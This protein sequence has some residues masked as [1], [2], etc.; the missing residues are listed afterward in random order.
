MGKSVCRAITLYSYHIPIKE[1]CLE[2]QY[3]TIGFF[4][5]MSTEALDIEYEKEDLKALWQY[6][7]KRTKE[8][9]GSY[10]FQNIFALADDEWNSNCTDE[11]FWSLPTDKQYP[12]TFVVCLQLKEYL[13]GYR[14]IRKQCEKF[15]T[16][17]ETYLE[18][19]L[20]YTYSSIDKNEFVVCLKCR[21]YHKAVQTIQKLHRE[22]A[23]CTYQKNVVVYGY[24][25][26]SVNHNV[27]DQMSQD[28]Y[29][30]LYEEKIESIC[31]KGITNSIK[32]EENGLMLDDK[33]YDFCEKLAK[34]LYFGGERREIIECDNGEFDGGNKDRTYDILGDDDFRYIAR[35]V[36]LGR[37]LY[38]YRRDGMLSYSDKGFAFYLFSSSLVL[39]TRTETDGKQNLDVNWV[40]EAGGRMAVMMVPKH[41]NEVAEILRNIYDIISSK[42]PMNDRILSIYYA[43]HQLLQSFK[44]LELSPAKRYDFFSMFP[45]FKMLVE[46]VRDKLE[47]EE[48]KKIV[49]QNEMFDFIH[50]ISMTF[51]SAQRTDIQFF[52][53]Q[54][55]NV[56]VHYAPAKLRAFY[57]AWILNLADLYKQFKGNDLKDYS[58]IFAPG[59]FGVTR[60][61]QLFFGGGETKRLMLVTL[62]DRSVYQ[63]K[64]LLIVLSHEAAHVGCERQRERRHKFAL[65]VCARVTILEMHAF[66]TWEING[67]KEH[68]NPDIFI[69]RIRND[70]QLLHEL[71]E[72]LFEEN[73]MIYQQFGAEEPGNIKR[74]DEC[75]RGRSRVH[76]SEAFTEML[77]KYGEKN[78]ADYC[79]QIKNEYIEAK[80]GSVT[81]ND[82]SACLNEIGIDVQKEM[83]EFIKGFHNVQLKKILKI[84]YNIEEEAFSDLITILTLEHSMEDYFLSF[85]ADEITEE[86]M[87]E[88]T[89]A[90]AVIVRMALVIETVSRIAD[91]SWLSANCPELKKNWGKEQLKQLCKKFPRG[92]IEEKT[93]G[94][95]LCYI[96][97]IKDSLDQIDAYQ[98]M[99]NVKE[100]GYTSISYAFLTDLEVWETFCEYLYIIAEA[101][102]NTLTAD[103]NMK[104]Y[105]HKCMM[106]NVYRNLNSKSFLDMVQIIE[107]FLCSYEQYWT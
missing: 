75:R 30:D 69:D 14:G 4:D 49:E 51:H 47:G 11:E 15:N 80:G 107:D 66:M 87:T 72:V 62:P 26:F 101:Y 12:L 79:C 100:H 33:Y 21:N 76:V 84:F 56:I 43:L 20:G 91:H 50:K 71:R 82:Y 60:V 39:N 57:A 9:D 24:S 27:L 23:L 38:E 92:S 90:T 65:E 89:D 32:D 2:P 31:F 19:G 77:R 81:D 48:G 63:I 102:V 46:I 45:P 6:T 93:T 16:I 85:T 55:F 37:L 105:N 1:S 36:K 40:Q 25:I 106:A 74:D 97:A 54:D 68:M 17:L 10:S 96:D 103:K 42:Y 70:R 18:T 5:G 64:R 34:K 104:I 78:I 94:K 28:N 35:E 59:M 7:T 53:I 88:A 61:R 58:F 67:R 13:N 95:V 83:F 99:Y 3:S 29:P 73:Q 41:C 52:Q 22:E 44:V 98:R 8:C 86:N